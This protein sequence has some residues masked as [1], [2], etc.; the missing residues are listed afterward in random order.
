M[1]STTSATGMSCGRC[2]TSAP[3]A[4]PSALAAEDREVV[5]RAPALDDVG[6]AA[7]EA[8]DL[9]GR[10][11]LEQ[12]EQPPD[13]RDRRERALGTRRVGDEHPRGER[14]AY[15]AEA[16]AAPARR[17]RVEA[18]AERI[19]AGDE[20]EYVALEGRVA[21]DGEVRPPEQVADPA[22]R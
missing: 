14:V 16:L 9:G 11:A 20:A 18:V 6:V 2:S 3:D 5:R 13:G 8:R 10:S 19:D 21:P 15:V 22:P 4:A 7:A 17:R 12:L 1:R